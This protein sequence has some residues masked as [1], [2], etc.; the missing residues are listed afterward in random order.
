IADETDFTT[1]DAGASSTY[2]MQC[3]ALLKNSFVV[4]KGQLKMSTSKTG[5]HGHAK[6]YLVGT[7]IFIGKKYEDMCLSTHKMD[8]P[9]IKR[10]DYQLMCIQDGYLFLTTETGEDV[11]VSV[12]CARSEEYAEAI[13]HC[14]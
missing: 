5:K 12:M 3:S 9:S 7:D 14:K 1:G 4:L 10:N 11:L 2:P 13:K 8:V 6:V